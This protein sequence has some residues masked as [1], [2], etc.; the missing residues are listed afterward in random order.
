MSVSFGLLPSG[1]ADITVEDRVCA[2]QTPEPFSTYVSDTRKAM[3][4]LGLKFH[5]DRPYNKNKPLA[6][7]IQQTINVRQANAPRPVN[8]KYEYSEMRKQHVLR[9]LRDERAQLDTAVA[10]RDDGRAADADRAR[11]TERARIAEERRVREEGR[12]LEEAAAAEREEAGIAAAREASAAADAAEEEA[13]AAALEAFAEEGADEEDVA[14][15]L[16]AVAE[17]GEGAA[18][19]IR[20]FKKRAHDEDGTPPALIWWRK[21]GPGRP[22]LGYPSWEAA[23]TKIYRPAAFRCACECAC[24]RERHT[25]ADE[26][27]EV[28]CPA[29]DKADHTYT[30]AMSVA[31][32]WPEYDGPDVAAPARWAASN[33]SMLYYIV[34][35]LCAANFAGGGACRGT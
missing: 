29:S 35:E 17:D 3:N 4:R 1:R 25:G 30:A 19:S 23:Q 6:T 2:S 11:E 31:N 32:G 14:A 15:A 22:R 10:A 33:K 34:C 21:P 5:P 8:C 28:V 7:E 26:E 16:E 13:A 24:A 27:W 20:S 18:E 9:E 12:A